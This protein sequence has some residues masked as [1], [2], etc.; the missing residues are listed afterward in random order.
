MTIARLQKFYGGPP[1]SWHTM[2]LALLDAYVRALPPLMGEEAFRVSA[3]VAMGAGT[4]EKSDRRRVIRDWQGMMDA[5]SPKV[6]LTDEQRR[7]E[8]QLRGIK[9]D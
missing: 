3:I 5:G 2:P 1:G 7:Y 4:I 9:V 8:A 6:R